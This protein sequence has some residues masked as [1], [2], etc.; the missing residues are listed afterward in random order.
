VLAAELNPLKKE[1]KEGLKNC[2]SLWNAVT[3]T[4]DDTNFAS[5]CNPSGQVLDIVPSK[6]SVSQQ[7]HKL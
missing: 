5:N 6:M 7:V 4:C 1:D 2:R 3:K